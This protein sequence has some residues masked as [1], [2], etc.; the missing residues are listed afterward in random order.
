MLPYTLLSIAALC[1]IAR[2]AD[3]PKALMVPYI[4]GQR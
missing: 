4:K 3:Y 2:R 1:I